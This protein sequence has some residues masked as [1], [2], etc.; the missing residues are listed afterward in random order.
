MAGD[1]VY[2]D[3]SVVLRRLFGQPG[4]ITNWSRWELAVT[5]ELMR[6][7]ALRTLDRLR[8]MGALTLPQLASLVTELREIVTGF[9]QVSLCPEILER[10]AG[11]FPAPVATLDAIHLATALLWVEHR[12]QPL[13]FLTHDRQLA[14]AAAACGLEVPSVA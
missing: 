14:M 4:A 12:R 7:E 9:E 1:R 11:S 10:A 6:V 2:L 5:N 3:S 13:T 8:V